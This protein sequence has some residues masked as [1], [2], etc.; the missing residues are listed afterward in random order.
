MVFQDPYMS[1]DPRQTVRR[2]LD[3]VLSFHTERPSEER[4][5]R[6]EEL[7]ESVGLP[8]R[9]LDALPR[10]LSGGQR[11]RAAI[12]R[13]LA[14]EPEVLVLDEAVSAL[15]TSVQAQILNLLAELRTRSR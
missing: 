11:Q 7:V 5:Q 12:A 15:D 10:E 6:I 13:A 1:L 4:A 8:K 3:E 2:M 9:A 14:S